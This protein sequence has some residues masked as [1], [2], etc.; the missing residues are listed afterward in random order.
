MFISFSSYNRSSLRPDVDKSIYGAFLALDPRQ[1][2]ISL[3]TLVCL[4]HMSKGAHLIMCIVHVCFAD[5]SFNCWKFWRRRV[6]LY[7]GQSLSA[8]GYSR[9]STYLC[10]QQWH[11]RFKYFEFKCLEH[12]ESSNCSDSEKKKVYKVKNNQ[13]VWYTH[14]SSPQNCKNLRY[15]FY[16][17]REDLVWI[18]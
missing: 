13:Y 9:T 3:R 14:Q 7:H 15:A 4:K 2:N 16:G 5:R 1:S 17:I 10:I 18:S 12:E 11:S 8:V 6:S